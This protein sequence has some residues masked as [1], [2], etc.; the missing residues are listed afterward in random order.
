MLPFQETLSL[1]WGCSSRNRRSS[2]SPRPPVDQGDRWSDYLQPGVS[3][4]CPGGWH[5]ALASLGP[6][7][8][9]PG[10]NDGSA[11]AAGAS[12]PSTDSVVKTTAM[13]FFMGSSND[14]W[15]GTGCVDA[16]PTVPAHDEP[17]K[18]RFL[19]RTGELQKAR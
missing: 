5:L 6:P 18:G 11:I 10:P 16:I 7:P 4:V 15:K 12:A 14:L 3:T 13:R 9:L 17:G 19:P 2:R 1:S 8:L